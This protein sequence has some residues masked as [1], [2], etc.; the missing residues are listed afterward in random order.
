MARRP[1]DLWREQVAEEAAEHA[2]GRTDELFM[3]ELFPEPLLTD[4][5]GALA[6]F[7]G[8]LRWLDPTS[9]D[10]VFDIVERVVR[11]L[12]R[13]NREHCGAGYETGERE[14]LCTYI[15]AALEEAGVDVAAVASR[16]RIDRW[17][18]T[19]EWRDW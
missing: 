14:E 16:R 9:D 5:D 8:D 11:D 13:I 7:E 10:A 19:D 12:N 4:T 6:A 17:E 3:A 15:D 2:A 1:S 18:I